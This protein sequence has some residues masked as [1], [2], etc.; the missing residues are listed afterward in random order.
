MSGKTGVSGLEIVGTLW[1]S[2]VGGGWS[3]LQNHHR[4]CYSYSCSLLLKGEPE[5]DNI[6]VL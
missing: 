4:I 6:I 1:E 5:L 2:H 3:V